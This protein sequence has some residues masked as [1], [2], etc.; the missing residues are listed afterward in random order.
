MLRRFLAAAFTAAAVAGAVAIHA[1]PAQAAGRV[2]QLGQD[3][4]GN[5]I[6]AGECTSK[7]C[8]IIEL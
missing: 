1:R 8:Q 2:Y 6:C 4:N 7:C 5:Y 3:K